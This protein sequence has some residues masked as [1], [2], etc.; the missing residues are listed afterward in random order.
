[1]KKKLYLTLIFAIILTF[2]SVLTVS[3][4]S[5][6]STYNMTGGVF[7]RDI[8]AR[9]S[10][11]THITPTQGTMNASMGIIRATKYWYGWDG[12]IKYVNSQSGGSVTHEAN[13]TYKIWLRNFAGHRWT[14][15]VTISWR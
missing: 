9:S 1:M 6:S 14:G 15:H 11:T 8:T 13:G 4:N 5:Y 2:I 7:S 12:P 10:I 3:A